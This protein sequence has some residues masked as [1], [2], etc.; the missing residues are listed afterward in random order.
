MANQ[1][2]KTMPTAPGV[3]E[4][5]IQT[6]IS[7]RAY[8]FWIARAFR[9]GSPEID[10]LRAEREIRGKAGAVRLRRTTSGL[11]LMAPPSS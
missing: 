7:Q 4:T 3:S 6:R 11:F 5:Q 10:W 2:I 8:E 9:N 1:P